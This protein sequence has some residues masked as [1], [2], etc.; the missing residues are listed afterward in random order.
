MKVIKIDKAKKG[1]SF[2]SAHE[3]ANE[4]AKS[5]IG[6]Y[7]NIAFYNGET[8]LVSPT[9]TA[10]A[11]DEK[12]DCGAESYARANGAILEVDVSE[13]FKFF[14]RPA[15]DDYSEPSPSPFNDYKNRTP[16]TDSW[17]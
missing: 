16:N 17:Y 1:L 3:M 5:E 6:E 11:I 2:N 7:I 9:L 12:S 13:S 14:Y 15:G 4:K 8:K 10:C